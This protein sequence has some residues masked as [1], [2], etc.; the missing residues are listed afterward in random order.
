M[1]K[2]IYAIAATCLL[3]MSAVAQAD[4]VTFTASRA[5][6]TTDFVD[7]LTL[8]K[9]D[10]QLGTLNSIRFELA[11]TV[12][13]DGGIESLDAASSVANIGLNATLALSSPNNANILSGSVGFSE[14]RTL[15]EFDGDLDFAGAS[16]YTMATRVSQVSN[17]F[18]ST[19]VND[20]AL[21][22]ALNGGN[23]NLGVSAS[24]L[25]EATGP[26]NVVSY[27]I[28]Q[29]G[30]QAR[31]TYDYTATPVPEPETYAMM[32]AGLAGLGFMARRKN[33]KKLG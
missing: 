32:L 6:D 8:G 4:T 31:V 20:F 16:G 7:F 1:K 5:L 9:F 17:S 14:S 23:I 15:A 21:F 3:G 28:T 10:T 33:V 19:D 27:F 13:T 2:I 11:G 29:A 30:A 18:V 12:V 25:S 24:A 22:S 26:G